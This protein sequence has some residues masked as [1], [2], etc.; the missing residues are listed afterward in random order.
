MEIVDSKFAKKIENGKIELT[1]FNGKTIVTT[2]DEITDATG[3][4]DNN[5]SD[6]NNSNVENAN[7]I[8]SITDSEG[9]IINQEDLIS[10][11]DNGEV[12]A[13]D[14]TFEATHTNRIINSAIYTQE[15]MA[16]DVTTF[17]AP[18][19]KPLI[20][21]HDID[22]EP[23]GRIINAYYDESQFLEDCGTINA[24]WRVTDSDAMKKFADGRYKTMSI[25]ASSNKIVCNT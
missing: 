1:D 3:D 4:F 7:I 12:I 19:G 20:K 24:T 8:C 14:V 15:S 16:E 2:F 5:F 21:N 22:Q 9:N 13:L 10:S 6:I 11:I 23:L 18:F 17:M 25:G